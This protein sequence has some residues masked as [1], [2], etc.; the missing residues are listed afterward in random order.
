TRRFSNIKSRWA[1]S[2]G[3]R[4]P[5]WRSSPSR[6]K[7]STAR[8]EVRSGPRRDAGRARDDQQQLTKLVDDRYPLGK[9]RQRHGRQPQPGYERDRHLNRVARDVGE[10]G[11]G[12]R[13]DFLL[14]EEVA[15]DR[16]LAVV[17]G[18]RFPPQAAAYSIMVRAEDELAGLFDGGGCDAHHRRAVLRRRQV[19]YQCRRHEIEGL[20]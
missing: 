4:R 10:I 1:R 11:R 6:E 5:C 7:A 18:L 15:V 16:Y 17:A 19:R 9:T 20:R 12:F 2:I 3:G 13:F 8:R 14:L